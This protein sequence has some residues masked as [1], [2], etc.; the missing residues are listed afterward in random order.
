MLKNYLKIAV[1][2]LLNNKMYSG[3]NLIGMG[4]AVACCVT[5]YVNYE[6]S[7]SYDAFHEQGDRIFRLNSYKMVNGERQNWAI[8]PRPMMEVLASKEPDFEKLAR[9]SYTSAIMRYE[10]QVLRQPLAYADPDFLQIFSFPIVRGDAG[11][12]HDPSAIVLTDETAQ[13]YFGD[14]NALGQQVVLTFEGQAAQMFTVKAIVQKPPMNSSLFFDAILPYQRIADLLHFEPDDWARWNGANFVLV[15]KDAEVKAVET[16]LQEHV[17]MANASNDNWQIDGFYLDPLNNLSDSMRELR[18]DPLN[19]G[20]PISAI[21]GPSVVAFLVLILACFNFMNT[22]IAFSARRLKEIGVRKVLGG[23]RRQLQQQFFGENV[24]LC[25]LSLL[26]GIGLAEIFVPAYD[27]LWPYTDMKLSYLDDYGVFVF[28]GSLLLF[29]GLLAGAYPAIYISRYNPSAIFRGKQQFGSS[30]LLSRVLLTFQFALC[31]LA[32]IMGMT[33]MQNAQFQREFN[34]GYQVEGMIAVPL[35][36]AENYPI[37]K[38]AIANYPAVQNVGATR[39]LIGMQTSVS[40]IAVGE[41]K[42]SV[43]TVYVGEHLFETMGLELA[44]GARLDAGLVSDRENSILVNESFVR[45]FQL[46]DIENTFVKMADKEFRVKGVVKDFLQSSLWRRVQ[47]C[48]LRLSEKEQYN[49]AIVSFAGVDE[50]EIA[51]FLR[52]KW[53]QLF[54]DLPYDGFF[55]TEV[56]REA[57]NINDSIQTT[58]IYIAIISILIA[59]MGLFALVSL[60]IARRTK[61]IGIRKILGASIFNIG[62]LISQQFVILL[63]IAAM[64]SVGMGY[65]SMNALLGSIWAYHVGVTPLPYFSAAAIIVLVA[66]VTVGL[67]VHKVARTNPIDALRYE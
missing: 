24:L 39:H 15:S 67:Q 9:F 28:L 1:R 61:E 37:F 5:A 53:Q 59:A 35:H 26:V 34:H 17:R 43:R 4:V 18:G 44:D 14:Q 60:N 47:P 50:K 41:Q 65:F 3:I 6:F 11:A 55:Q 8:S 2:N 22:S 38:E 13:K 29:T 36:D 31:M 25:L 52:G 42:S 66:Y 19:G 51:A 63:A 46:G 62:G 32:V 49:Y 54:P 16:R 58:A 30:S 57:R 27:S 12:L 21:A 10:E 20:M 64:L 23:M 33:M 7:Q 48:I 45:E 40:D 56:I